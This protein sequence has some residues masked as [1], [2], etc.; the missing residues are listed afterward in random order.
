MGLLSPWASS[1][2]DR[3]GQSL[4]PAAWM[5]WKGKPA[6][7]SSRKKSSIRWFMVD[8]PR[9]PQKEATSGLSSV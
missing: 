1:S 4:L 6:S 9:L 8:A 2:D 3:W 5:W 7:R